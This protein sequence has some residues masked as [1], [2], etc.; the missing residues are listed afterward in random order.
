VC[1][2]VSCS[3][4]IDYRLTLTK[5]VTMYTAI[6]RNKEDSGNESVAGKLRDDQAMKIRRRQRSRDARVKAGISTTRSMS[7]RD[8][9][10]DGDD[11]NNRDNQLRRTKSFV[12]ANNAR[13][14][15]VIDSI[16]Q[17]RRVMS[18]VTGTSPRH[19]TPLK[20]RQN[21]VI[22]KTPAASDAGDPNLS[23]I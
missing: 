21:D 17:A 19:S 15:H 13:R 18:D 20:T 7:N 3:C 12:S 22:G 5:A 6:N 16:T 23:G 8:A 11:N 14:Y 4:T 2:D 1:Y 9:H 10:D